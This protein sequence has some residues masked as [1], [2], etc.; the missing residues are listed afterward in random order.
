MLGAAGDNADVGRCERRLDPPTSPRFA[1]DLVARD[2]IEYGV[3]RRA[4]DANQVPAGLVAEH[5]DDFI[6]IV[7]ESGD[8]LTA[9]AA[10]CAPAG[11]TGLEHDDRDAGLRELQRRGESRIPGADDGHVGPA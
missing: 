9:I 11:L 10:R 3:R 4:G 7:F 2:E 1:L 8:H 6:R 5:R